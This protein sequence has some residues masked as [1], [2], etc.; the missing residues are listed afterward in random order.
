MAFVK[1]TRKVEIIRD[2]RKFTFVPGDVL[3]P[4][5]W[6]GLAKLIE[7]GYQNKEQRVSEKKNG[8]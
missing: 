6:P 5:K 1:I 8:T 7:P 2:G 3:N 4:D